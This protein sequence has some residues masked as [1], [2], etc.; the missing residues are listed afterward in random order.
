[1]KEK[2]LIFMKKWQ[3]AKNNTFNNVFRFLNVFFP[4]YRF[5]LICKKLLYFHKSW[6]VFFGKIFSTT[7]L[8]PILKINK[9]LQIY[10]FENNMSL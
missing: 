2:T 4:H 8:F 9:N 10:L 3:L 6:L 7:L 1:M 5:L